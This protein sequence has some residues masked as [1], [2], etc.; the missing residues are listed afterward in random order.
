MKQSYDIKKY[1]NSI[2]ILESS[3]Y[4]QEQLLQNLK[5]EIHIYEKGLSVLGT[6]SPNAHGKVDE[7]QE[8]LEM[9]E[10]DQTPFL[11]RIRTETIPGL[12]WYFDE[13]F[14]TKGA[15]FAFI[16]FVIYYIF[17][18]VYSTFHFFTYIKFTIIVELIFTLFTLSRYYKEV[19]NVKKK[20]QIIK[21]Q[22]LDIDKKNNE[23]L[24]IRDIQKDN[25]K[26]EIYFLNGKINETKDLL[27]KYYDLNI[28]YPKYRNL[29]Y[30]S[31]LNEYLE[32]GRCDQLEGHEGAYN[33]LEHEIRLNLII[34]KLDIIIK[35]LERIKN[36]QFML[37]TT[38]KNSN[39]SCNKI[40]AELKDLNRKL[41]NLDHSVQISNYN[42]QIT[43]NNTQFLQYYML[44]KG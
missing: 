17:S 36:N 32:S 34:N 33:L 39:Q 12:N 1:V 40:L 14:V 35:D 24:R 5:S 18:G 21:K 29:I 15:V 11:D 30:I 2:F 41:N 16:T 31:S 20:N 10:R 8:M 42:S 28:I 37:Y 9:W 7:V 44:I 38:I 43:S 27:K 25:M 26:K 6:D 19:Q 13:D 4:S 3:L 22:N 23:L